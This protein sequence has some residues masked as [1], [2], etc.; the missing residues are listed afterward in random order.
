M[1]W[2]PF[3][4]SNAVRLFLRDNLAILSPDEAP[5]APTNYLARPGRPTAHEF[6]A[7][8]DLVELSD[9]GRQ[10][11]IWS[12]RA[13]GLSRSNLVVRSRRMIYA[14]QAIGA[15]IHLVDSEPVVLFGRA[16]DCEYAGE[17]QYVVDLDFIPIPATGPIAQW[18]E[19]AKHG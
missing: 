9:T 8:L 4:D 15:L 18:A 6:T 1:G 2:P 19:E 11:A 13:I 10:L 7:E 5:A 3:D 17:G 12:A 14:H 16:V